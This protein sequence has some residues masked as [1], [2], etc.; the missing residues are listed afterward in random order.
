MGDEAVEM[1][2]DL[3]IPLSPARSTRRCVGEMQPSHARRRGTRD[4]GH[5]WLPERRGVEARV[6]AAPSRRSAVARRAAPVLDRRLLGGACSP[7]R[8]CA[9]SRAR[10]RSS[11]GRDVATA[12]RRASWPCR[13]SPGRSCAA[14]PVAGGTTAAGLIGVGRGRHWC[15]PSA[16][17][18]PTCR[19]PAGRW[20]RPR[21]AAALGL[22]PRARCWSEPWHAAAGRRAGGGRRHVL[23]LRRPD[24]ADRRRQ[25]PASARRCRRRR[26]TAPGYDGAAVI[27]TTDFVFLGLLGGAALRCDLRP[28]LTLPLLRALVLGVDAAAHAARSRPCPALPLLSRRSCCPTSDAAVELAGPAVGADRPATRANARPQRRR[29]GRPRAP[30]GAGARRLLAAAGR[31]TCRAGR[32]RRGLRR[33][34]LRRPAAAPAWPS[35]PGASTCSTSTRRPAAAA[36]APGPRAER[37]PR[38]ACWRST[39]AAGCAD[40]IVATRRPR[41]ARPAAAGRRPASAWRRHRSASRRTT[42]SSA[43]SSTASCC[44]PGC[45]TW[46]SAASASTRCC[47]RPGR[48]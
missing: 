11:T 24:E 31:G 8:G 16:A 5:R 9:W 17:R 4:A 23:R 12:G 37:A 36:V 19:R 6:L 48:R 20:A 34:Q 25:G 46:S 47:G 10:R 3:E 26:S 32:E 42:S 7:P 14:L 2:N 41:R 38:A 27:G 15:S 44:S 43:T 21:R 1:L 45:A 29:D 35:A 18:S 33:R 40:R 39:P 30:L 28:R 13:C 22:R